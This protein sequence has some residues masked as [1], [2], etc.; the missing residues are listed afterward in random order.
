M[1]K[2]YTVSQN[3]EKSMKEF[4]QFLDNLVNLCILG[5]NEKVIKY[6]KKFF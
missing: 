2:W 3:D 5:F 6:I 1:V 4:M